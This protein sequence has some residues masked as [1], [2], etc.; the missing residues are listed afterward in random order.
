MP[1]AKQ[2]SPSHWMPIRPLGTNF[3]SVASSLRRIHTN[4]GL[5]AAHTV[6]RQS[7]TGDNGRINDVWILAFRGR[8]GF[9]KMEYGKME[10]GNVAPR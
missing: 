3:L 1:D 2:C 7:F 5:G 9:M 8:R 4:G 10:Y 6:H